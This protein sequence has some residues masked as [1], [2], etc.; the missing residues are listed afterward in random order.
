VSIHT[1]TICS[2]PFDPET[3]GGIIGDL[4]ILPTAFC[5]TCWAGLR[6]VCEQFRLPVCCEKCDWCEDDE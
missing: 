1:C 3:E 5:P 4:G 6:D 2:G